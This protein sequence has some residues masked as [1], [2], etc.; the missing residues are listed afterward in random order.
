MPKLSRSNQELSTLQHL[1]SHQTP[2]PEAYNPKLLEV[3][4][5][6]HPKQ[7]AWTSF[8]CTEFTSLCPKT[9]Q[10]DFA[11]IFVNY[12]A[13]EKMVESKSLKLYLGSFRQHGGFHEDCIQTICNDL[14]K[15]LKA[16][17]LEVIGE[18]TPRGGITIYPFCQKANQE[19]AYQELKKTRLMGY[20]PGRY[21]LDLG[22]IY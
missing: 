14:D 11:R 3:F 4:A 13:H 7:I 1:G 2:F 16:R 21:T 10:P 5:N 22:R 9:H 8:V 6:K 18:F 19:K 20:A 17:Y 12:I 15:V